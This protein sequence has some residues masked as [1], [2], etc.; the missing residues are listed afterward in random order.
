M[1]STGT[2]IR[3]CMQDLY[4]QDVVEM[5]ERET[6]KYEIWT[7][8][9]PDHP[10]FHQAYQMLW[11][12]FG[13]AGEMEREDAIRSF[14]L[15]N[16]FEPVPSGTFMKYYMVVARGADGRVRGVRDGTVLINPAYCA[17]LCAVY[18]SHIYMSEDA[19]GTVLSYWLRIAAVE[20]A[21]QYMADLHL[22]GLIRLPEPHR[23]GRYF[24]MRL[25]LTAEMEYFAPE[26]TLSLQRILFYG[27]GGFD[28]INPRHFPYC[29][30][31]YRDLAE[32]D[33]TGNQ[34]VPF[35]ILLRR[36]GRERQ[37]WVPVDEAEATLHLLYDDFAAFCRPQDL[38]D[39][40][41][42]VMARLR[43]RRDRGNERVELLPLPTQSNNLHRLKRL[44]RPRVYQR[45][46]RDNK[47]AQEYLAGRTPA[48]LQAGWVDGQIRHIANHLD[49]RSPWVYGSR[50]KEFTFMGTPDQ[51]AW[52]PPDYEDTQEIEVVRP[53]PEQGG[54]RARRLG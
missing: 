11:D 30:P 42:K 17:D 51:P 36:M 34:P 52:E 28:V 31:D 33:R 21:V 50:E 15:D 49:S 27:R 4:H 32:I 26:D 45:F 38:S 2:R 9:S 53:G 14:L 10:D 25:N 16:P 7:I 22:R 5:I 19:R 47:I 48:E 43:A 40:L 8:D 44:W 18:L 24:G 12:A 37:A 54:G 46:Y 29:Q 23:P 35:M 20:V 1:S 13:E 41:D 6:R 3:L 39:N